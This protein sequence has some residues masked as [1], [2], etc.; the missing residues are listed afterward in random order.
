MK[1][2]NMK[3]KQPACIPHDNKNFLCTNFQ[4]PKI[5]IVLSNV[6]Q[7]KMHQQLI[8]IFNKVHNGAIKVTIPTERSFYDEKRISGI[9]NP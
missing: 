9:Q 4:V 2:Q 5:I 8:D 1:L 6:P 7:L 3:D